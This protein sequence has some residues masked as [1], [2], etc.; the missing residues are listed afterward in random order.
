MGVD[1]HKRGIGAFSHLTRGLYRHA[2]CDIHQIPG[3]PDHG[4]VNHPDGD[5]SKPVQNYLNWKVS[6]DVACFEGMGQDVIAMNIG[7]AFCLGIPDWCSLV[8]YVAINRFTVPKEKVLRMLAKDFRRAIRMLKGYGITLSIDGG[9]TADLPDQ[10]RTLDVAGAIYAHRYRL[11]EVLTGEDI[12]AGDL[13]IGVESGGKA[14]YEEVPAGTLMCNGITMVRHCLMARKLADM[15]PE[16]SEPGSPYYGRFM[17]GD[18]PELLGGSTVGEEITRP[19]RIFA[20]IQKGVLE[21]F[22]SAVHG[23][24]YNTGGGATKCLRIGNGVR[25]VKD[26]MPEPPGIFRLVQQ[27]GRVRPREMREDFN[28]G[29]GLDVIADAGAAYEIRDYITE[30]FGVGAWRIGKVRRA[31]G[32]NKLRMETPEGN[33]NFPSR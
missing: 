6:H 2:F 22:G 25:Y 24:V 27:E 7:D 8:D 20:P 13:I 32:C 16:I 15:Y 19:T 26:S 31:R 11:G 23:M 5:G 33:F 1:V 10:L 17:P 18:K 28:L 21:K 3:E 14:V 4:Y 12:K 29:V 30:E 9:E